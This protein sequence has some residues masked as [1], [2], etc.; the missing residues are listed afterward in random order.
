MHADKIKNPILM[1]HG[2]NDDNP[3]TF[4]IQ[5]QRMFQA[6]KG[7]G[8]IAKLVMLPLEGHGY[9]ARESVLHTKP[10]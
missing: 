7:N 1:I 3:G 5:S 9:R 6:I 2:E 10:R 8:G 4:P